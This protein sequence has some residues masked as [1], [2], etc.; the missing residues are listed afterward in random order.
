MASENKRH[1]EVRLRKLGILTL[2]CSMA[3]LLFVFFLFGIVVGNN[4][5]T[6]PE[7]ISRQWPAQ[8]LQWCGL[9]EYDKITPV[10][11]EKHEERQQG[12]REVEVV[13]D[14]VVP[15]AQPDQEEPLPPVQEKPPPV[16]EKPTPQKDVPPQVKPKAAAPPPAPS[17]K[18]IEEILKD[19]GKKNSGKKYL[20][21]VT[22][23]KDKKI[24]EEVVAKIA[25]IGFKAQISRVDLQEKGIWYRV[26]VPAMKGQKEAEEAA[27]KI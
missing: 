24:A 26:T 25:K 14:V 21:Q 11:V 20:V 16:R 27:Q 13:P 12:I 5:E 17:A 4:L 18:K 10:A 1:F 2:V 19:D 23:H 8:F 7:K 3:G 15:H 6:Y 9:L 22:S